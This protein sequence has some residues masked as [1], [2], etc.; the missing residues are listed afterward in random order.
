MNEVSPWGRKEPEFQLFPADSK[1]FSWEGYIY[2]LLLK[3]PF[4]VQGIC[5]E[6]DKQ[7]LFKWNKP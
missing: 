4:N 7:T 1:V 2:L 5:P 6:E 3:Q